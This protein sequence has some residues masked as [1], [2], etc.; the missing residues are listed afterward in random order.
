MTDPKGN[1][2]RLRE[3]VERLP[4]RA[5]YAKV[6]ARSACEGSGTTGWS[7]AAPEPPCFVMEEDEEDIDVLCWQFNG[8]YR[9]P[10]LSVL[11]V[12]SVLWKGTALAVPLRQQE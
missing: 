7:L 11:R 4:M 5:T 2:D 3:S 1:P 10:C 6:R 8:Y 9:P 12:L